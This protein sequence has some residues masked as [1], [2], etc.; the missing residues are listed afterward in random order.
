M[1][2]FFLK[3]WRDLKRKKIRSIPIF[4]V[5]I[6]GGIAS[7]MYSNIYVTWFEATNASWGN[8]RY[9][10][11]LVTVTPMDAKNLTRIVNQVK[12]NTNLDPDFEIRSF[13]EV[14]VS[15]DTGGSGITTQLYG[16]N[17][18]RPLHVDM[19]YYYSDET[20]D[21]SS[22]PNVSVVDKYTAELNDWQIGSNLIISGI[23][24]VEPF[25][26]STI[27][28]VDSPEYLVAPGAAAAEFFDFWSGPVIWMRYT[29]LLSIT[30]NEIQANQMVFHFKDPSKRNLFLGELI[31]VLGEENVI[32]TE[33]RNWYIEVVGLELLGMGVIM[34]IAF[35]GIAA[36]L[37]FIVLKRIIEEEL[38][39]LGLFK[40]LGFTN[41]ELIISTIIYSL[42]IS[43]IGGIIGSICGAIVGI[44]LSDYMIFELAGIK[45]LPTVGGISPI[46]L[47]P[48]VCYFL[49]TCILTTMGSL[50]AVRKIFKMRPLDAMKPKAK[51][52]P[53]KLT[54]VERIVTKFR[55]LSPLT[56][57]SIRSLFQ[58]KRK[59]IF[60]LAGIFLATFISFF[61]TNVT[62]NYYS[63]FDKQINYY[64]NWDIQVIF[65]NYQNESQISTILQENAGLINEN[66]PA[67]L[68]P[69]RF[70][71]DLS[72]IYSLTGL[73]TNSNMRRFDNNIFPAE[74]ELAIT[75]DLALKFK[76][77]TGDDINIKVFNATHTL[78]IG[79][80]LN[81][82]SGS[83]IYCTIDTARMLAGLD[84]SDSNI[85][86]IKATDPDQLS[87][88]LELESDVHKVINKNDLKETIELINNLTMLLISLALFAGLLVG[89]SIAVTIVSISISERKHD[90]ISFRALGVSNKELF[91]TILLELIIAGIGGL[92][93]GFIGSLF[94]TNALYDFAATV[95]VILIFELSP[96]SI[97]IT[98]ANVGLGIVLATYFS[99]RSLF[100]TSISEE[101][102]S[103]I[104]G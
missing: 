87:S 32:N 91:N 13:L 46:S 11:L 20:L 83:G 104:I 28:H 62:F 103:R 8:Q 97:G 15:K 75:K 47:L 53:G 65:R 77:G 57:F 26:V 42:I 76:V 74:G 63:G 16:I 21:K 95:G 84:N 44:S 34:A 96:V 39:T 94:L 60:I 56:K 2:L 40:S 58:D 66:E 69:F 25:T 54:Y 4:I 36:I 38:P 73:V 24:G 101:T 33:G 19:L 64:Q 79:N 35:T 43:L 30:N 37:L 7:I 81:D 71:E 9:H 70:S 67:V 50:F 92:V 85:L 80:V 5:I 93:F 72:R 68:V 17:G 1:K 86:F 61:G 89:V 59:S 23:E 78:T 98:I 48:A 49:L 90:F 55:S 12:I 45:K 31:T 6:I 52:D 51:F 22:S 29:D 41:R 10:H 27:A 3:A 100:R 88:K 18:T 102:V 99:L 14:K 82:L